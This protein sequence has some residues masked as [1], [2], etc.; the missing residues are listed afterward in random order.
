MQSPAYHTVTTDI[1]VVTWN[2][3]TTLDRCL[4]ALQRHRPPGTKVIVVDNGSSDR[5][6]EIL[7][8]Y[9]NEISETII[10]SGNRGFAAACNQ[11]ASAGRSSTIL[12]LNPDCEI[13]EGTIFSLFA[14]LE[15]DSTVLAVGANLIGDDG[16]PQRGFAVRSLPRPV[17]LCCEALLVNQVFPR[18]PWN[19]HYRLLDWPF[20]QNAEVE[21]PAG[22]CLMVK[23]SAFDGIGGFDE[24]FYPAWFEDV[25]LCLRLRS[26]GGRIVYCADAPVVHSGGSSVRVMVAGLASEL[27]FLNMV[28]YSRKHF[29][30]VRTVVLRGALVIG[31]LKRLVILRL[32]PQVFF[33]MHK[34]VSVED[35]SQVVQESRRAYWRIVKG[36]IG[37]WRL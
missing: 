3:A 20:Q 14:C 35:A 27:F 24:Q 30:F 17:D 9:R 8:A 12:F 31:M 16:L 28:R 22:A 15:S 25:D 33:Q 34:D 2:S 21:Q 37:Q 19:R 6:P 1:V 7:Q 32:F 36:A 4:S 11:G 13:R 10:N 5:T 29:G 26:Q 23:R 18:N